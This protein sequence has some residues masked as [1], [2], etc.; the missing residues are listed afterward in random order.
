MCQRYLPA[1]TFI[2]LAQGYAYAT[3]SMIYSIQFT[4]TAR[5]APTGIST[6]GT[7][8]ATVIAT[9]YAS[10]TPVF[11]SATISNGSIVVT[12]GVTAILGNPGR[13]SGGTIL[14]T[15]CEL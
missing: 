2:D 8:T 15:G 1:I 7:F 14:W 13:F 10:V 6:T 3:N 12:A 9:N 11:N 4:V 5:V